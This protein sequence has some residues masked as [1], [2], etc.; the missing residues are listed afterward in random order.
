MKIGVL[1]LYGIKHW[2]VNVNQHAEQKKIALRYLTTTLEI[3]RD[4]TLKYEAKLTTC[5]IFFTISFPK[6]R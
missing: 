2:A 3:K 6:L 5:Y 4:R 1:T